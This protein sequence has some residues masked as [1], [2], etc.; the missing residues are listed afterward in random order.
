MLILGPRTHST[1]PNSCML[2]SL[3]HAQEAYSASLHEHQ[4]HSITNL[5]P[6]EHQHLLKSTSTMTDSMLHTGSNDLASSLLRSVCA[7]QIPASH[8]ASSASSPYK[9]MLRNGW[10]VCWRCLY[11][12]P[13]TCQLRTRRCGGWGGVIGGD[14][15]AGKH[16]TVPRVRTRTHVSRWGHEALSSQPDPPRGRIILRG[17]PRCIRRCAAFPR[18]EAWRRYRCGGRHGRVV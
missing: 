16:S 15:C 7:Y 2:L 1:T 5:E 13:G 14:C 3:Q 8:V 17:A 6:T 4:H 10:A 12:E 11:R 18:C 9:Y